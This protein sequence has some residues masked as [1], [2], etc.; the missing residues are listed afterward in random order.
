MNIRQRDS[1]AKFLYD[2]SKGLLLALVVAVLTK[3]AGLLSVT[4]LVLLAGYTFMVA[5]YLEGGDDDP[6]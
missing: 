4:F 1:V 2:L 3:K 6:R 5:Y